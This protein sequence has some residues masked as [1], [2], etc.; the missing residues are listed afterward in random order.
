[1]A[2]N[3]SYAKGSD[4]LADAG[5]LTIDGSGADTNAVEL[6]E[7]FGGG[8]ADIYREID[9]DGDGTFEV[10]VKVDSFSGSFH[11]QLNALLCSQSENVRLR[12]NN[13]SGGT[14]DFGATGIEVND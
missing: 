5:D 13:K 1:M 4:G 14:A 6:Q 12:I 7:I 8:A 10:S 2:V 11:G 3:D 9:P